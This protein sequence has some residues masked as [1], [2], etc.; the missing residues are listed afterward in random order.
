MAVVVGETSSQ[1]GSSARQLTGVHVVD[2][3]H[4]VHQDQASLVPADRICPSRP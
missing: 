2:C 3:Q 4:Q 1:T